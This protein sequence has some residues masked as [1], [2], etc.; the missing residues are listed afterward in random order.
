MIDGTLLILS[1]LYMLHNRIYKPKFR[2][3]YSLQDFVV[4]HLHLSEQDN[5]YQIYATN[6]NYCT[7]NHIVDWLPVILALR[8][9]CGRLENVNRNLQQYNEIFWFLGS[10]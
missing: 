7:L 10:N 4:I 1:V 3:K 6:R 5:R 2:P 9:F 8:I